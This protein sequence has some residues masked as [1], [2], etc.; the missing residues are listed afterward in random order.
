MGKVKCSTYLAGLKVTVAPLMEKQVYLWFVGESIILLA[1]ERELSL[2]PCIVSIS[3]N[4]L[5][6][7]LVL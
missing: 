7:V 5:V 2:S 6:H 4:V 3:M 1:V